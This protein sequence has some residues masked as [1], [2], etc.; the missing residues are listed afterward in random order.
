MASHYVF[1]VKGTEKEGMRISGSLYSAI[2]DTIDYYKNDKFPYLLARNSFMGRF[3]IP[4]NV[5][6]FKG[7]VNNAGK[8]V[9]AHPLLEYF[10][11]GKYALAKRVTNHEA[12]VHLATLLDLCD[13]CIG[14][15]K[16]ID[17]KIEDGCP[18]HHAL[19][20]RA[21]LDERLMKWTYPV[22]AKSLADYGTN[23]I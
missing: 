23:M 3:I 11:K 7:D 10:D 5:E 18:S 17:V 19:S 9:L 2:I 22:S 16:G 4:A 6:G 15:K 20:L 1:R 13:L 21:R 14:G 12:A 8:I